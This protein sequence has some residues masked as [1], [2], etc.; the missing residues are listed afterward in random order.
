[1]K[2]YFTY[3]GKLDERCEQG[4]GCSYELQDHRGM[5]PNPKWPKETPENFYSYDWII[6]HSDGMHLLVYDDDGV[7]HYNDQ[8]FNDSA[9]ARQHRIKF[10]PKGVDAMEWHHWHVNSFNAEIRSPKRLRW[11]DKHL[12]WDLTMIISKLLYKGDDRRFELN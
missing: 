3:T 1:M 5:T 4:C 2:D 8:A 11:G 9:L 10:I 6:E 12:R 7:I